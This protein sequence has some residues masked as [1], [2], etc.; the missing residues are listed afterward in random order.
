[1]KIMRK[2]IEIH[3]LS[4]KFLVAVSIPRKY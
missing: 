3:E 1:L 2:E 4:G